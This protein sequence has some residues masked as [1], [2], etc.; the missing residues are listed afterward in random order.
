MNEQMAPV[1]TPFY[2]DHLYPLQDQVLNAI[3]ALATDFYLTGGTAVSRAYLHHRVSDDLDMFVNYDARFPTW[4]G[5]VVDALS[6]QSLWQTVVIL[7]EQ[8]FVR[9][10]LTTGDITLK[11]EMVNDVPS[12]IGVIRQHPQLGRIDSPENILANKLTALI[13]REEPRD[14]A[15]VWGLCTKLGLSIRYVADSQ[16]AINSPIAAATFSSSAGALGLIMMI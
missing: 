11:V 8:F 10:L 6:T 15:D 1:D 4:S 2:F 9:L 16:T 7:R 12:H 5:A 13:N 3:N 14:L